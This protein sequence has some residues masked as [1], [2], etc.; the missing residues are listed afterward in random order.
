MIY[1]TE[2]HG[3]SDLVVVVPGRGRV[4]VELK[5]TVLQ[6]R[7]EVRSVTLVMLDEQTAL[8]PVVLRK[9]PLAAIIKKERLRLLRSPDLSEQTERGTRR[10]RQTLS[11]TDLRNVADL[12]MAAWQQ[13]LPV[14]RYVAEHRDIAVSTAARQILLARQRGFL[15]MNINPSR[16][17]T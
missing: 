3:A 17:K 7:P 4:Q 5:W 12:Y 8:E 16:K 11:D 6:G 14:Q 15:S 1:Q 10:V 13:G 2:G 9:I